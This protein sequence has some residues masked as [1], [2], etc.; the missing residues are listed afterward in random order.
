[1]NESLPE[2]VAE[3]RAIAAEAEGSF[4]ALRGEQLNWKPAADAWSVA[5]CFD[6]LIRIN[7]AYFP[8]LHRIQTGGYVPTWRDRVPFLGRLIAAMVLKA[9]QPQATRKFKATAAVMPASSALDADIIAR[10][11][12]HQQEVVG[13][14]ER[15]ALRGDLGAMMLTSAVAPAA[16]YSALDAFRILLAHERRHMA[17]AVRVTQAAGFPRDGGVRT[18]PR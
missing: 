5:Q 9:V 4:G 2:L 15:T 18:L 7:S 8:Q 10:F 13:H 16:F 14:M 3:A 11:T 17:Q 1:M 6:H 12:A